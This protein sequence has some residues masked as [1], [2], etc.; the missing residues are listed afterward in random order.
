MVTFGIAAL[1]ERTLGLA[2]QHSPFVSDSLVAF[3]NHEEE[4]DEDTNFVV[5]L[6]H[7]ASLSD[8]NGLNGGGCVTRARIS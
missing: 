4:Y 3:W 6:L 8:I 2:L 5:F 7:V 1:L